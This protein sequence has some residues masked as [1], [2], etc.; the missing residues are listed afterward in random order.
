MTIIQALFTFLNTYH[1]RSNALT[2]RTSRYKHNYF[3]VC[4]HKHDI[5]CTVQT[6]MLKNECVSPTTAYEATAH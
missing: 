5:K 6:H 4:V 1:S 3:F 2:N